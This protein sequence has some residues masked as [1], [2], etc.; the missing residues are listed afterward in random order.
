M[1]SDEIFGVGG[2]VG[3]ESTEGGVAVAESVGRRGGVVHVATE[4]VEEGDEGVDDG[5]DRALAGA[6]EAFDG[7]V[8]GGQKGN[9]GAGGGGGEKRFE[10]GFARD[11]TAGGL[12]GGNGGGGGG[13]VE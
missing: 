4:I 12:V 13:G 1:F 5:A 7:L 2:D 6:G 9:V 11:A 8:E 3:V 10:V